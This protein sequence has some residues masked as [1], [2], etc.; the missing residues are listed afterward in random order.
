LLPA[1]IPETGY[2]AL[3]CVRKRACRPRV[4]ASIEITITA[5]VI[6]TYQIVYGDNI[7]KPYDPCAVSIRRTRVHVV[8]YPENSVKQALY[9]GTYIIRIY[10]TFHMN[11]EHAYMYD[12]NPEL[13]VRSILRPPLRHSVSRLLQHFYQRHR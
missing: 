12:S 7:R 11:P 4:Y 10:Y 9:V 8:R 6:V 1:F 5:L 3:C 13:R 2:S